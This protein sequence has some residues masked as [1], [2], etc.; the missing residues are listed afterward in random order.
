VPGA[1]GAWRREAIAKLGGFPSDT[2]AEDQDL[3]IMIQRAGYKVIF[4]QDAVAWTEAP[5]TMAGLAKQRFR[6]AFGTLQCLW[7]HRRVTLNPLYGALG[8]VALPQVWLFQIGLALVSPLVDLLLIAQVIRTLTDYLQHGEQFNSGNLIVTASYYAVFMTVDLTAALIAFF[9]EKKEDR[10]L[11]WWLILQRF[12]YRQ[13]MY[14]VVAKSV[15]KA[16]QG[17]LVGWGKL[18]RKATVTTSKV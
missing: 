11:L 14:Y 10:S 18:E 1:V 7:K 3:T 16:L 9:M 17:R 8:L 5:D 4:D 6:W 13:I 2:L 12:G 15:L